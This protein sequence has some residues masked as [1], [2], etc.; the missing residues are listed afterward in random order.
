M[1]FPKKGFKIFTKVDIELE[2]SAALYFYS[3]MFE[4]CSIQ[5]KTPNFWL[6]ISHFIFIL[7]AILAVF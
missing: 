1:F 6:L 3:A 2:I 5:G 4:T 7:S